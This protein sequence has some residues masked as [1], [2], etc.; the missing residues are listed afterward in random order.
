[1]AKRFAGQVAFITGG[2]SGIGAA[3]GVAFAR[4]GARVALASRR[5]DSLA[6]V[7]EAIRADGGK[8]IALRCDVRDRASLDAA[9]AMTLK[10]FGSIDVAVANAGFGVMGPLTKL[11]TEDYRRQ[12]ETNVFG[13]IDTVYAILPHLQASR[14]RL[15]IVSSV[16]GKIGRPNLSAYA[17]SKFAMCGFA[18]SIW[19]ELADHGVSVTC[20]NPGVVESEFRRI[21]NDGNVRDEWSEP[22]MPMF[23]MS[24]E[25]AA[26]GILRAMYRRR[27]EAN[28][29]FHGAFGI[30]VN[31]HAPWVVRMGQ[32]ALTKGRVESFDRSAR[33]DD[34]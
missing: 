31:R 21:D 25:R 12:Y 32:R 29:T 30:F 33:E 11:S 22:M 13:A 6:E 23:V 17:S 19:Y 27:F 9:V 16:V 26:K 2:S 1:M 24:A 3:L 10:N 20:I 5:E 8:A 15:G 14:G 34:D 4:E 28:I 7:V 18:E